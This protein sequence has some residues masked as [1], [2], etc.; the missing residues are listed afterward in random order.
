VVWLV[1]MEWWIAGGESVSSALT[2]D[3]VVKG[4]GFARLFC[5]SGVGCAARLGWGR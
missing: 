2:V 4:V 1:V 5:C 3:R